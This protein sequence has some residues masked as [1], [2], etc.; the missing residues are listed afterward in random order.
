MGN[1]KF[2]TKLIIGQDQIKE[3]NL[4]FLWIQWKVLHRILRFMG[5][6]E[7]SARRKVHSIKGIYDKI[8]VIS[9]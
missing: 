3:E 2:S 5:H 9:Y 8:G 1:E 6:N 4:N 7:S